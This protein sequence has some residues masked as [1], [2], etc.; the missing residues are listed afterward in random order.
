[1]LDVASGTLSQLTFGLSPH[2]PIWTPDGGGITLGAPSASGWRI[3]H[4]PRAGRRG[5]GRMLETENRP[6][7]TPGLPTGGCSSSRSEARTRA[8]TSSPPTWAP[9]DSSTGRRPLVATPFYEQNAA[10]SPD[11]RFLAYESDELDGVFEIY[12]IPARRRPRVRVSTR[13]AAAAL[14]SGR[15]A[16]LLLLLRT[17]W[18]SPLDYTVAADRFVAKAVVAV[19]GRQAEGEAPCPVACW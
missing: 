8:G 1:M 19:W 9:P 5:G 7:R 18:A 11:G 12:V 10:L 4:R 16:V 15:P 13:G 17:G 2:R 6:T 14:R 3:L